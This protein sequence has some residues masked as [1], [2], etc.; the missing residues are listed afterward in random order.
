MIT[1]NKDNIYQV[2]LIKAYAAKE[3]IKED[4]SGIAKSFDI[5]R[6]MEDL[7]IIT[8]Q[9]T[10]ITP[11]QKALIK[12]AGNLAVA[13][14]TNN[15]SSYIGTK[16]STESLKTTSSEEIIKTAE[17]F[18]STWE[19]LTKQAN[20]LNLLLSNQKTNLVQ[21]IEKLSNPDPE[22]VRKTLIV[23][24]PVMLHGTNK[25]IVYTSDLLVNT[26]K[27]IKCLETRL[28]DY[29]VSTFNNVQSVINSGFA[30]FS[31]NSILVAKEELNAGVNFISRSKDTLI[32]DISIGTNYT[33]RVDGEDNLVLVKRTN[34]ENVKFEVT[35][36]ETNIEGF[37]SLGVD[38]LA[39][40]KMSQVAIIDF[41][42]SNNNTGVE[43][44][45]NSIQNLLGTSEVLNN[46]IYEYTDLFTK[47][48]NGVNEELGFI[49]YL[50]RYIYALT[51]FLNSL[52]FE[53]QI[54]EG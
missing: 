2:N 41:L 36:T 28:R 21:L 10:Q 19:K 16:I 25:Q 51:D 47:V 3:E 4:L 37:H 38:S 49:M 39:L 48:C 31:T 27:T 5:A 46:L 18:I 23:K 20:E 12:I 32:T 24:L 33:P 13:G 7:S 22:L 44:F 35:L 17:S 53:E 30:N 9:V 6:S 54:N 45:K 14:T 52:V 29:T 8:G 42:A 11:E 15:A 50:S 1:T 43:F 26:N 40:L 34:Q